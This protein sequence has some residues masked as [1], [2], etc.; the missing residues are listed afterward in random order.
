MYCQKC[1]RQIQD[2]VAFCSSCGNNLSVSTTQPQIKK[3][4]SII[5]AGA[6][7]VFVAFG[8][9]VISAIEL[10][11]N[12]DIIAYSNGGVIALQIFYSLTALLML[13]M[14][15]I[16]LKRDIHKKYFAVISL[17]LSIIYL[18]LTSLVKNMFSNAVN[19]SHFTES[20]YV[21]TS[22]NADGIFIL[23][24]IFIVGCIIGAIGTFSY[25]NKKDFE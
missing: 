13:V 12:P 17:V 7:I 6:I 15:I 3:F 14:H 10:M 11:V 5:I 22:A 2:D 20:G 8:L 19:G 4:F 24:A 16:L 9:H 21:S 1:G 23:P 25:T 18:I